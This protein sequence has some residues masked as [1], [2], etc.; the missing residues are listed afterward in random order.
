MFPPEVEKLQ[1]QIAPLVIRINKAAQNPK[2]SAAD[3]RG[4]EREALRLNAQLNDL[5]E[6]YGYPSLEIGRAQSEGT[7]LF[8]ALLALLMRASA[9]ALTRQEAERR[10]TDLRQL[11]LKCVRLA[12]EVDG[13]NSMFLIDFE[14]RLKKLAGIERNLDNVFAGNLGRPPKA[15]G[16]YVATAVYGSYDAPPVLVLRRFRDERLERSRRGRALVR[17]YYKVSPPLATRLRSATTMNRAVRAVLDRVVRYLERGQ[18]RGDDCS[19][20][21]R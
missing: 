20:T 16:C 12:P 13:L 15:G 7:V 5:A 8:S 3:I 14:D 19:R 1:A 17:V 18:R 2:V 21:I 6:Q 10:I 9:G 11:Y 4:W